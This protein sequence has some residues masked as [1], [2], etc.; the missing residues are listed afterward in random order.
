MKKTFLCYFMK[1]RS[2]CCKHEAR[3]KGMCRGLKGMC[4]QTLVTLHSLLHQN[5]FEATVAMTNQE[6]CRG[7]PLCRPLLPKNV[8]IFMQFCRYLTQNRLTSPPPPHRPLLIWDMPLTN[9]RVTFEFYSTIA[10]GWTI[11]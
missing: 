11:P 4:Q 2:Y 10:I 9:G 8:F 7:T 1:L 3:C 6:G 5:S